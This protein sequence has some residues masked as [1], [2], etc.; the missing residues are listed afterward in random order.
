MRPHIPEFTRPRVPTSPRPHVPTSPRP[1]V[2]TFPGPHVPT[3]LS[4][5]VPTSQVP[6]PRP[7]FSHSPA[8]DTTWRYQAESKCYI[9]APAWQPILHVITWKLILMKEE[10]PQVMMRLT[11]T[12]AHCCKGKPLQQWYAPMV[13]TINLLR[14]NAQKNQANCGYS[15]KPNLP[16]FSGYNK[17][18]MTL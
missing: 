7:T 9:Q 16:S 15:L 2:P 10:N 13:A 11:E 4:P 6:R 14:A 3:S 12:L 8:K 5:H 1:R 18:L 17:V